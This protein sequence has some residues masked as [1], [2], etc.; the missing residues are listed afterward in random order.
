MATKKIQDFTN[1]GN[2]SSGD[3]F[4][5][6]RV[7]GTTVRIT[8]PG[9]YYPGSTDV[10]VADGGTGRS[11]ATA[12]AVVLGGTT[13]TGAYQSAATGTAGQ[14]FV[15]AGA[16]AVPTWTT[17]TYPTASGTSGKILQ[18]DGTNIGYSTATWPTAATNTKFIIGNGTDYVES[19][20]TIPTSAGATALKY[21]RSDGTNYVL[22]TATL[23]DTPSTAGKVLVSDGTNWITS[24]P[25]FPNASATTRKII[26]SDGTNWT[27]STETY[28][29]PGSAGNV[30]RSDGTNWT[31]GKA[32]LT[33]DVTGTLPVANGGTG[34]ASTTAYAVL[35]GGT[36]TTG[37]LQSIASVGN[38]GEVL[39]SN[40]ASALP[41]FQAAPAGTEVTQAEQETATNTTHY[42]SAAKQQYHPSAAKF[43]IEAD[44]AG[45]SNLISYNV[46]SITDIGT[47]VL[48]VTINVDFSSANWCVT[49]GLTDGA[50]VSVLQVSSK[51][52]GSFNVQC[53]NSS[54]QALRDPSTSYSIVGFGDQ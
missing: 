2:A 24:T 13:A 30:L 48:T 45:T 29:V 23:S 38:S 52:A 46:T 34:V 17:P 11:T 10:V 50:T 31:A 6:E 16:S 49:T 44:G 53:A 14:L 18:S 25:T 43:W 36:T 51:A 26:V 22:S 37:A 35:C 32:V 3:K 27:A 12:Y 9:G 41:T 20:S 19:T 21:L 28:A 8:Y 54:T 4:L 1:I 47:G 33:T 5:G 42:V 40:G 7:D 39:T 15:S